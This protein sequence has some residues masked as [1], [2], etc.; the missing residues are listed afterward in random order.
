MIKLII[1]TDL[2]LFF[3]LDLLTSFIM[4]SYIIYAHSLTSHL[5]T[6]FMQDVRTFSPGF[7][8]RPL[9]LRLRGREAGELP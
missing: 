8:L 1:K 7:I 3:P 4:T 9:I 2:L 5:C 6:H